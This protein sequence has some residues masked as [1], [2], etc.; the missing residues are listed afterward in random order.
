MGEDGAG[1]YVKMVHNGIEYGEMQVWGM[2]NEIMLIYLVTQLIGEAYHL[3]KDV[4]GMKHDEMSAVSYGSNFSIKCPHL[5]LQVLTEWNKGDLDSFLI[6]ITA[7]IL[8]FKDDKG[9][10]LVEKIR[11]AA[12]QVSHD[13]IVKN[14]KHLI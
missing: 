7:D 2:W 10:Y 1:H 5:Q 13:A 12:G 11:D 6:E 3:M 9:D 4:L 14:V 8:K